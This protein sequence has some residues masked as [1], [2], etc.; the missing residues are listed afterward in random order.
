M[1]E[2]RP[3]VL[4][5]RPGPAGFHVDLRVPA[6]LACFPDHFPGAPM[7]PGVVQLNWAFELAR[8]HFALPPRFRQLDRLK[9][10][11]VVGPGSTISLDLSFDAARGELSFC[12]RDSAGR[13]C[14]SGRFGFAAD[15]AGV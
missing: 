7:L 14:S 3:D 1:A 12:Y 11:R 4:A 13:E 10:T 15:G 9:F 5:T 2:L 6:D 8:P